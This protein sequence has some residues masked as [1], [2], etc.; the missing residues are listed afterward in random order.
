LILGVLLEYI[1]HF[2][3]LCFAG[4]QQNTDYQSGLYIPAK[5]RLSKWFIYSSKT[6]IIKV[7]YIFQQNTDYQSGLYIPAKH[8]LSKTL[9]LGVLLEYLTHFDNLCFAGIYKPL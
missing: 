4:I 6:Q 9:I 3:N 1:N 5:H 7:G 2:D 8:R